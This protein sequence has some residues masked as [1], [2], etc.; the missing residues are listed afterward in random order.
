M[1]SATLRELKHRARRMHKAALA[2]EPTALNRLRM[3][4]VGPEVQL[5]R[6][7]CLRT[8][9]RELGFQGWAHLTRVLRGE[10]QEDFGTL[11]Y[12]P[13]ASAHWNIWSAHYREAARIR[14]EHGGYL[15]AYKRHFFIADGDYIETLG[16]D[17]NA[18]HWLAIG[19]D[20]VQPQDLD[21]RAALYGARIAAHYRDSQA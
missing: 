7:R 3:A 1:V 13:G 15:L 21:A 10:S 17:P 5:T 16:L 12:P 4:G 19:R 11:L 2:G 14:A 20:W 6:G 9:A 18:A 8:I